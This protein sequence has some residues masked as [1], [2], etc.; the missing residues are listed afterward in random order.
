MSVGDFSS[1]IIVDPCDEW[2]LK[3]LRVRVLNSFE[4]PRAV[5]CMMPFCHLIIG[6]PGQ[7]RIVDHV[8]G[9]TLDNR[10]DNLQVIPPSHNSMKK[11]STPTPGVIQQRGKYLAK[12]GPHRRKGFEF[13]VDAAR[14][15]DAFRRGLGVRGMPLN[16]P[17]IGEYGA[18][19][20]QRLS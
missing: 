19:G 7:G 17:E 20:S 12:S 13:F 8:N 4:G 2:M 5:I 9:N 18:D 3:A 16:F 15:A 1:D 11:H 14:A 10:R 6:R